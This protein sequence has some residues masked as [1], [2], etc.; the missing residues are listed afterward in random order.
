MSTRN[1]AIAIVGITETTERLKA[2][3][4]PNALKKAEDYVSTL[5]DAA[6]GRYYIDYPCD[7]E[8]LA[9]VG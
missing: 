3:D 5:P 6:T 7:R 8:L 2:F 9:E 4:G 1:Y